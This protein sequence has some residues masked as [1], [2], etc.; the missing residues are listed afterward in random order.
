MT[1]AKMQIV[2]LTAAM[3]AIIAVVGVFE[4]PLPPAVA[5][6]KGWSLQNACFA[7][8]HWW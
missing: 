5:G 8:T 7:L 2:T 1:Q 6:E 3:A 4:V